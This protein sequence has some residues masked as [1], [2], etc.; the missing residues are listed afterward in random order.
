MMVALTRAWP[1]LGATSKSTSSSSS[2]Y[3][4]FIVIGAAFYF[5]IYRPQQRKAK[6]LREQSS[7]YD[8]GDEVL[9]A[10]GIVG[11]II[12]I[13]GDRVTLETS[14]GA[15]FGVLKP[16]VLRKL[17][18]PGSSGID[19]DDGYDAEG[20]HDEHDEHGG[21]DDAD[22]E[23][24]TEDSD[25]ST[26]DQP[27]PAERNGPRP[28]ASP[29]AGDAAADD[30]PAGRGGGSSNVTKRESG[31]ENSGSDGPSII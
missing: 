10:G 14:V 28:G 29:A 9:T 15:S 25:E 20:E 17:E 21:D 30:H 23:G 13:D 7:S 27:D 31:D 4:I 24:Q 3:L 18:D 11:H 16:Y 1:L 19:E 2:I 5:L 22:H 8:V 26:D 6:A 12:D